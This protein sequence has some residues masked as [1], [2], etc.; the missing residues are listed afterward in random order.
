MNVYKVVYIGIKRKCGN[1][2]TSALSVSVHNLVH[3]NQILKLIKS[4]DYL[5]LGLLLKAHI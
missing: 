1:N 3:M 4:G 5:V 2:K